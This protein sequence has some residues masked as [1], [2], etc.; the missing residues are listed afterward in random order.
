MSLPQ[1]KSLG[2][3]A[4]Q[5]MLKIGR[6][7]LHKLPNGMVWYGLNA[8]IHHLSH[9]KRG[10]P[11]K[12]DFLLLEVVQDINELD[13]VWV[14]QSLDIQSGMVRVHVSESVSVGTYASSCSSMIIS[15]ALIVKQV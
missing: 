15:Q 14:I 8:Q 7:V 13:D 2:R 4:V 5:H 10:I 6:T 1:R 9:N 3:G 12:V 11:Y